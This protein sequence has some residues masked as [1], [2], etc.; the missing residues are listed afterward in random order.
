MSSSKRT[1]IYAGDAGGVVETKLDS[2]QGASCCVLVKQQYA[3]YRSYA[4]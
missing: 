2:K 3:A 1:Y 4:F